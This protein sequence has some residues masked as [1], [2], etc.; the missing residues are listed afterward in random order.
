MSEPLRT[1]NDPFQPHLTTRPSM[2]AAGAGL[3]VVDSLPE[4][5]LELGSR[6][7]KA[8]DSAA[9][10]T[11]EKRPHCLASLSA[12]VSS[13][14]F[15]GADLAIM[16]KFAEAHG[17]ALVREDHDIEV[18]HIHLRC[19]DW[20]GDTVVVLEDRVSPYAWLARR[21]GLAV[22]LD[23]I[24]RAD[25]VPDVLN[26]MVWCGNVEV[27]DDLLLKDSRIYAASMRAAEATGTTTFGD[28][29]VFH[30]ALVRRVDIL[31]LG[32]CVAIGRG[33]LPVVDWFLTKGVDEARPRSRIVRDINI[34]KMPA[35][36]AAI[37]NK[38][39]ELLRRLWPL[40]FGSAGS[41]GS[42]GPTDDLAQLMWFHARDIEVMRALKDLNV[43]GGIR[44]K[45]LWM[46][47]LIHHFFDDISVFEDRLQA[48]WNIGEFAEIGF[49][50][51]YDEE[52]IRE[53]RYYRD[54]TDIV[55]VLGVLHGKE[56]VTAV[57]D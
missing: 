10:E 43:A 52:F 28:P 37:D 41:A 51:L 18:P 47:V 3:E 35:I 42:A 54:A 53:L 12:E 1:R 31:Q 24:G 14:E 50:D 9:E 13:L 22:V 2:A 26:L 8:R 27:L 15:G 36:W 46:E 17:E 29:W 7:R 44:N 30:D 49:A 11:E 48:L 21:G 5:V 33:D 20:F 32:L 25:R 23:V 57:F 38:R 16:R 34:V 56:L 6:K 55:E 4:P 39:P 40:V 45:D 19:N